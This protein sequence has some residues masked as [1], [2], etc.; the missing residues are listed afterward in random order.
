MYLK[1]YYLRLFSQIKV[2][3]NVGPFYSYFYEI[4]R[5][6]FSIVKSENYRLLEYYIVIMALNCYF[7]ANYIMRASN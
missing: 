7:G 1:E 6:I 4:V 5:A 3:R 2:T